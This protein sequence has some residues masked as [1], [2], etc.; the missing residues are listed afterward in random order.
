M[1]LIGLMVNKASIYLAVFI[2]ITGIEIS[3]SEL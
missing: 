2:Y 3:E 1:L